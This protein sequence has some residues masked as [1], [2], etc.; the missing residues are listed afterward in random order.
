M[1][2][3]PGAGSPRRNSADP[4]YIHIRAHMSAFKR[5]R[6]L[7]FAELPKTISGKI[8]PSICAGAS[9]RHG[10]GASPTAAPG[11]P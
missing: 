4:I 6:R 1:A 8:R 9:E 3:A 11:N 10:A 7:E 2:L 5:V